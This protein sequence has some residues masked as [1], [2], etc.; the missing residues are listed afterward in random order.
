MFSTLAF[1]HALGPVAGYALTVD[2]ASLVSRAGI[3]FIERLP[4]AQGT[5]ADGDLRRDGE[6]PLLEI[7]EQLAPALGTLALA[8]LEA[9]ELLL[10]LRRRADHDE[11]ALRGGLHPGLEIDAVGPEVDIAAGGEIA[12]LPAVVLRLP[13]G[14]EARDDARRQVRRVWAEE[15]GQCLLEVAGGD[16]AQVEHRQQRI[17]AR[18]TP[19]PFRQD[20]R[21]EPDLFLG[22]CRPVPDFG[23]PDGERPDPGLDLALRTVPVPHDAL[24]AIGEPFAGEPVEERPD[25]GLKRAREHPARAFPC[26][27]GERVVDRFRLAQL[28][29][30]GI[31][32][33]GVSLLLEVLAG[34]STRHDTPPS[35]LASPSFGHSYSGS[36]ESVCHISISG[37]KT[38]EPMALPGESAAI[39]PPAPM[40]GSW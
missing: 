12:A 32:R 30:A 4:E 13:P 24:T 23:A 3:D 25:L 26:D 39:T 36:E 19:R 16:A 2:P 14:R 10:P 34:F 5:V 20:A 28:D 9:D 7:D 1:G 38:S 6:A 31:F 40:N 18:R 8:D 29:D 37:P 21:R 35:H 22:V 17:E 33:H 27:L 15:C 11:H